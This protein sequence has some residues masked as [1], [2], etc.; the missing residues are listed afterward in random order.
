MGP[1]QANFM[2]VWPVLCHWCRNE[3]GS[4]FVLMLCCCHLQIENFSN[5]YYFVLVILTVLFRL[6]SL[7]E[8]QS[9]MNR[10]DKA[11][12]FLHCFLDILF[13][14]MIFGRSRMYRI[15]IDLQKLEVKYMQVCC[16]YD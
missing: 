10:G 3:E 2:K 4:L 5:S 13:A 16:V 8:T 1:G 11:Q 7:M 14:Y 15:L 9:V 12:T 6:Q